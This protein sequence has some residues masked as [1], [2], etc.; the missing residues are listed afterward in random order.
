MPKKQ[1]NIR[2]SPAAEKALKYLVRKYGTKTT[3]IEVALQQLYTQALK[4]QA[5]EGPPKAAKK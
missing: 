4:Q 2:I 5:A 3:V 1:I